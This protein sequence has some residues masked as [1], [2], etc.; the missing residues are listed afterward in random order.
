[1]G[2]AFEAV[3]AFL[4]A[5][6]AAQCRSVGVAD[7]GRRVIRKDTWH[8]RQIADIP[9]DDPEKRDDGGLVGGDRI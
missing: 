1:V 4:N 2:R 9:V 8:R 7:H 5:S 3:A 6:S